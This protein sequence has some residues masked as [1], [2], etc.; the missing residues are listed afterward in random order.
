MMIQLCSPAYRVNI[1][2]IQ[3]FYET[4]I[5]FSSTRDENV[6]GVL[7][8]TADSILDQLQNEECSL[9]HH[10]RALSILVW[11]VEILEYIGIPLDRQTQDEVEGCANAL[12]GEYLRRGRYNDVDV[13]WALEWASKRTIEAMAPQVPGSFFENIGVQ[14]KCVEGIT[15]L[16]DVA[17]IADVSHYQGVE[18]LAGLQDVEGL[19]GVTGVQGLAGLAF[20]T[21]LP[22]VGGL[23][24]RE[25]LMGLGDLAGLADLV[26]LVDLADLAD[27][28]GLQRRRSNTT[29]A[30][31]P[32]CASIAR[33]ALDATPESQH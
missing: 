22:R 23:V 29:Y 21:R 11:L 12:T 33:L 15:N 24:V 18:E 19:Q 7:R 30:D 16:Q 9:A 4:K 8:D 5:T 3:E 31:I 20:L 26:G 14:V 13:L 17:L 6:I 10:V 32:R 25:G 28:T 2:S 27:L 1:R